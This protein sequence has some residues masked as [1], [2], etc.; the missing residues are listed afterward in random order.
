M[1]LDEL[2]QEYVET[3]NRPPNAWGQHIHEKTGL[4]SHQYR[5]RIS[6]IYGNDAT[7]KAI[8]KAFNDSQNG[9][10]GAIRRWDKCDVIAEYDSNLNMTLQELCRKSKWEISELKALL[11]Y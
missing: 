1:T 2:V 5:I 8:D 11:L 9:F 4:I 6:E 3:L 7:R 10:C